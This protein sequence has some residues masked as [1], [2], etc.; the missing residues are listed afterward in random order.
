[1]ASTTF[2]LRGDGRVTVRTVCL[3]LLAWTLLL[4]YAFV[5]VWRELGEAIGA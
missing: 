4:A 3:W 5:L 2:D 1:M